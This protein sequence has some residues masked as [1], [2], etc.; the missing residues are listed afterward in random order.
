MALKSDE[1]RFQGCHRR[2]VART[3][4]IGAQADED[5]TRWADT[6][7]TLKLLLALVFTL[8]RPHNLNH[9]PSLSVCKTIN[10]PRFCRSDYRQISPT[11]IARGDDEIEILY[12]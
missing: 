12:R 8:P 3:R 9:R 2:P 5:G 11:P 6:P 4:Q 10:L 1:R 7:P